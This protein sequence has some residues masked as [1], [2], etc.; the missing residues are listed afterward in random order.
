MKESHA[1]ETRRRM[2][3]KKYDKELRKLQTELCH[4]QE[5]VKL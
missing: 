5:W 2:K 3:R 4:A 1:V